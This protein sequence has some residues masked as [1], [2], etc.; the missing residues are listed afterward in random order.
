MACHTKR[1]RSFIFFPSFH[2]RAHTLSS[3]TQMPYSASLSEPPLLLLIFSSTQQ[4]SCPVIECVRA[5]VRACVRGS[6]GASAFVNST[7]SRS[8]CV[9]QYT[10]LPSDIM[11]MRKQSQGLQLAGESK[12]TEMRPK[13]DH[14]T[15]T[16]THV[17]TR[18]H[19]HI[20]VIL[21][22]SQVAHTPRSRRRQ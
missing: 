6:E 12:K 11:A 17:H 10:I 2:K 8:V 18:T 22:S 3:Q 19:T 5:C 15:H 4:P 1:Q 14:T 20:Q 13:Q 9:C 16:Y 21:S 7:H